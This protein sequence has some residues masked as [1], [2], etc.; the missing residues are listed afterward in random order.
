VN[1]SLNPQSIIDRSLGFIKLDDATYESVERDTS[2]TTE[3]GIVVA[4]VAVAGA[5]GA[6]D[7]GGG[8]IIGTL[9]GAFISWIV[10]SYLLFMVGTRLLPSG[11]TQADLGQL[12]RVVGYAQVIGVVSII[13]IIGDAGEVIAALIGLWGIVMFVKAI[14]SALEMST[15]RAIATAIVSYIVLIIIAAII[16][17][18]FGGGSILL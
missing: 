16:G 14:K 18:I 13:G 17:A 4:L 9:I 6:I 3:A 12:L 5:I 2:A 11:N 1:A 7:D 8:A 10:I 15:G